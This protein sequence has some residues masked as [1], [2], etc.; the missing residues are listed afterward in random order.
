MYL[1]VLRMAY[2]ACVLSVLSSDMIFW[3]NSSYN[4][5]IFKIQRRIIRVITVLIL[6]TPAVHCLDS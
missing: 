2:F 5:S 1:E 4:K 6:G 3:G